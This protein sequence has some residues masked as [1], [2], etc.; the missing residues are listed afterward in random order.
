LDPFTQIYETP[1][2]SLVHWTKVSDVTQTSLVLLVLHGQ[3]KGDKRDTQNVECFLGP[4]LELAWSLL[5]TG[6]NK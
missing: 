1:E 5:S 4:W 6:P 2:L 3:V